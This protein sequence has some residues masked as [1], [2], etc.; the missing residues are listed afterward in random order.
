MKSTSAVDDG[1]N[2]Y[3]LPGRGNYDRAWQRLNQVACPDCGATTKRLTVD[4][5]TA[6]IV[7]GD[8]EQR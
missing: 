1:R 7:C 5:R 6:T 3:G 8:A 4:K 2:P